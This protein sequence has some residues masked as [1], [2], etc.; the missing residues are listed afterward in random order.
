MRILY[1]FLLRLHPRRFRERF[2]EEML[3]VFEEARGTLGAG[4]LMADAIVSLIRQ[5]VSRP[6]PQ[7]A[8]GNTAELASGVPMFR[9]FERYTPRLAALLQ[10]AVLSAIVF[11]A[12]VFAAINGARP[13][14][15]L[16]GSPDPRS[17]VLSVT[18]SSIEPKTPDATVRVPPPA[19]DPW[20]NFASH[21]F[22]IIYVLDALDAN[23][24]YVISADEIAAAP[25]VLRRL[26]LNGDGKLTAEEC[27]MCLGAGSFPGCRGEYTVDD[28]HGR[29]ERSPEELDRMRTI[30][31]RVNPVL[32]ALDTDHDSEISASEIRNALAALKRLDLN[33]DGLLLPVE[34][35]PES[36]AREI[37]LRGK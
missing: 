26:D 4:R 14:K 22:K 8:T 32:A 36:V 19:I 35:A 12:L 31:M 5:W 1:A 20:R 6:Q 13:F 16:I 29:I 2:T 34:I 37:L 10:G 28:E 23:H 17:G 27:G 9:T 18:R 15:F 25:A 7:P 11:C 21:Y 33:G 30:F 24:D 3:D